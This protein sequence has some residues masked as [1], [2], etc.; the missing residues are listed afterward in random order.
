M[1]QQEFNLLLLLLLLAILLFIYVLY[2]YF[3][4]YLP[5]A[6]E[7]RYIKGEMARS[8]GREYLYW[9]KKLKHLYIRSIPLIGRFLV[10]LIK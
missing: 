6:S 2:F 10:Y 1:R 8:E 3:N 9:K 7:K 5:F 4:V